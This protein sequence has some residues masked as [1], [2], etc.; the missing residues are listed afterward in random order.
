MQL[1]HLKR[2]ENI[3]HIAFNYFDSDSDVNQLQATICDLPRVTSISSNFDIYHDRG[4]LFIKFTN[5]D[6]ITFA[7]EIRPNLDSFSTYIFTDAGGNDMDTLALDSI[8]GNDA[9]HSL[10]QHLAKVLY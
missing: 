4:P 10:P 1:H 6:L 7:K 8:L 5:I 9:R 2:N 3:I